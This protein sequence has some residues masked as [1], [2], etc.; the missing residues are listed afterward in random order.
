MPQVKGKYITVAGSITSRYPNQTNKVNAR[1]FAQIGRHFKEFEPE[2]WYDTKWIKS[3]L[4]EY[5]K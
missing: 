4:N 2:E 5:V 3:F 1:L